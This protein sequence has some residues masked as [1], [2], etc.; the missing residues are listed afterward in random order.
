MRAPA[1][2][3]GLQESGV[4]VPTNP[5]R[6]LQHLHSLEHLAVTEGIGRSCCS[7]ELYELLLDLSEGLR[8][9]PDNRASE[10]DGLGKEMILYL[11][12]HFAEDISLDNLADRFGL[13]PEYLCTLFKAA[14]G[15]TVMQYLRRIRIHQAKIR[16]MDSPDARLQ[17]IAEA[18]GFH[19]VS[20]F[21]KVFREA[22]GFTPQ[23]YRLGL[24]EAGKESHPL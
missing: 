9:L 14:T 6:Y 15:E 17:E 18:C 13:T 20:Y 21:G 16:L 22:T 8:R 1:G 19:S 11:E 7:A 23:G 3:P 4:Y 10:G 2:N 12:D 24:V 5:E